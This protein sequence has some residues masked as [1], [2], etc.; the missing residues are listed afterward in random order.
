MVHAPLAIGTRLPEVL[1]AQTPFDVAAGALQSWLDGDGAAFASRTTRPD[2]HRKRASWDLVLQHATLGSQRVQFTIPR[3][4]PA[5]VPQVYFDKNLCLALPHIEETG[6]FC[7]GVAP[8]PQDYA[9]PVGAA[10]AV[11][12]AL[13]DFWQ[14]SNDVTWVLSEFHKERLSYWQRFCEKFR[15]ERKLP[16]PQEVRVALSP[17]EG[18]TEGQLASYFLQ[19]PN[20]RSKLLLATVGEADPQVLAARHGWSVGTLVLGHVLFV[21]VPDNVRW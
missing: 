11:L 16:T 15:I 10:K 5:S 13:D 1:T 18:V 4:F 12:K 3:D 17:L 20:S 2:P 9:Q 14:K 8:S 19:G 6:R 7:H 21:P